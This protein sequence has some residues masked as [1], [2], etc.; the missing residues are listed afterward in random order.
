[1]QDGVCLLIRMDEEIRTH[2]DA[3]RY[4]EAFEL[5]LG[6]YQ[7]KVFRLACSILGNQSVAEEAAQEIFV[8]IWRALPGYR[9][10]ASISTWVYAIARNTSLSALKTASA[11]RTISLDE[12]RVRIAVPPREEARGPDLTRLVAQLPRKYREVITLF[13]MEERSYKEVA[14]LLDLPMGTVKTYLHRAKK[15]L[16]VAMLRSKMTEGGR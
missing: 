10:M 14:R 9:G 2:I 5:V 11:H 16:A 7:N 3:K 1:M 12:A 4:T 13:Y 15:H 6:Q 8:R